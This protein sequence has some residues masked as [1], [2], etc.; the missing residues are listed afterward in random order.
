M[1]CID[2]IISHYE[3]HLKNAIKAAINNGKHLHK[4]ES[5]TEELCKIIN[6]VY[7]GI[8][9]VDK[10]HQHGEYSFQKLL[11]DLNKYN[12]ID[13]IPNHMG[14]TDI[15]IDNAAFFQTSSK[16]MARASSLGNEFKVIT[17]L[18]NQKLQYMNVD[19]FLTGDFSE[20]NENFFDRRGTFLQNHLMTFCK[21]GQLLADYCR[22]VRIVINQTCPIFI[23]SGVFIYKE[24][25]LVSILERNIKKLIDF[26]HG[27]YPVNLNI[28]LIPN[29]L[30]HVDELQNP[31][32][33]TN[34]QNFEM[35]KTDFTVK[36]LSPLNGQL[37]GEAY[38]Y[39]YI[40]SIK[41]KN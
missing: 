14:G 5:Y 34:I 16:N 1:N 23:C 8:T 27:L 13:W 31:S 39:P 9:A 40:I 2:T 12:H 33:Y 22:G 41:R 24:N 7:Y 4:E 11:I 25:T 30:L 3:T 20:S 21:E 35:N 37:N 36:V 32:V 29:V 26:F 38:F 6:N 19:Y 10:K 18:L 28:T 15:V 17:N